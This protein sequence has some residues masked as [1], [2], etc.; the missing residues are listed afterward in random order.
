MLNLGELH[1]SEFKREPVAGYFTS[2][3]FQI[4][5]S[6]CIAQDDVDNQ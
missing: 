5:L 3:L 4:R 6:L 2:I 1:D